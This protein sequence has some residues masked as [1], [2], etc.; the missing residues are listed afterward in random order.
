MK[1]AVTAQAIFIYFY[2]GKGYTASSGVYNGN[3][4]IAGHF[5]ATDPLKP[6]FTYNKA[7]FSP[8]PNFTFSFTDGYNTYSNVDP[9]TIITEHEGFEFSISTDDNAMPTLWFISL[10]RSAPAGG[11]KSFEMSTGKDARPASFDNAKAERLL[12]ENAEEIGKGEVH[13][14]GVW[15]TNSV[16][17]PPS[18]L[19]LS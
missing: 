18:N 15:T 17:V 2:K 9:H 13:S 6:N 4:S 11:D 16:L 8:D 1:H 3:M 12:G 10:R 7:D 19:T 5:T 14:E